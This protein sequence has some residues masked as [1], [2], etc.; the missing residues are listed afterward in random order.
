MC[1]AKNYIKA[2]GKEIDLLLNGFQTTLSGF[3]YIGRS[4]KGFEYKLCETERTNQKFSDI[5]ERFQ[6]S[7]RCYQVPES[8]VP[9]TPCK[10]DNAFCITGAKAVVDKQTG[11]KNVHIFLMDNSAKS[12]PNDHS[13]DQH[14]IVKDEH[15][16]C[17]PP[18]TIQLAAEIATIEKITEETVDISPEARDAVDC[19]YEHYSLPCNIAP[20]LKALMKGDDLELPCYKVAEIKDEDFV[21]LTDNNRPGNSE[22]RNFVNNALCTPDFTI[23]IGPPGSGKTTG[24]VELILQLVKRGKRIL[25]VAST[26]V[27]VDNILEKLQEHLD[28]SCVKRYGDEKSEKI[29][30][31]GKNFIVGKAFA[32]TEYKA[33]QQRLNAVPQKK[34]K[35]YRKELLQYCNPRDN[36][37]LY[38][39]L[40]ESAPITAG[41]TFG[42]AL[43][44][45]EK[46]G[47][48]DEPPFDYLIIDEASK[49]TVQEFLVPA[50]LCKHWIVVG[51][52]KQ[53]PPY[54]DDDHLAENL[55]ICYPEDTNK[56]REY[57]VASDTLLASTGSG[58]RQNVILI[59]KESNMDAYLYKKYCNQNEVLFADADN[60][61]YKSDM[62]Y[63]NIIVGSL[64]SFQKYRD[65]LS[66]RIT[67]VRPARDKLTN[68]IL[69]EVEMQEW[70]SIAR[71]NRENLFHRMDE[72]G[73]KEWHDELSWRLIRM[74]EQRDNNVNVDYS[75]LD[76]LKQ[77][78]L[79][80]I[81]DGDKDNCIK[82][83]HNFEQMYLPS[84]MEELIQGYGE[85]KD[86]AL[87]RGIPKEQ[88]DNRCIKL[89]YQH[90]SDQSIAQLASDEFYNG[91]AMRSEHMIGKREWNYN[92]FKHHNHWEHIK[93]FCDCKNRNKK[94]LMWIENELKKFG[95]FANQ[96]PQKGKKWSVATLSFYKEQ[97]DELKK[98][99]RKVFKD[100]KHV[101]YSAGSVDSFQGHE[102]DIVFLSYANQV[103]TCFIG[104]PNRYNVAITRARYMMVHVG[105]WTAMNKAQGG[106]GRIAQKLKDVTN[107]I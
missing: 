16:L 29:S 45:M 105:N 64:K 21:L 42:A 101:E 80:L 104:A 72:N 5:Q 14:G 32:K 46:L 50:V 60:D 62:P 100:N 24:T 88:L 26:N 68:R 13:R 96:N 7:T 34:L 51:D 90:R 38:S 93:G 98:I 99:C 63:A 82:N 48:K 76:R 39:F 86:I 28:K 73:P 1:T 85:Y 8:E 59:E 54:V 33:L 67:A 36:E 55:K 18:S 102:A 22:Q 75:T 81:P 53:L 9:R 25:L 27:A 84:F 95:S 12:N 70:V 30:H 65:F 2:I 19:F 69:H 92:R 74:F 37:M 56:K 79:A 52:I 58:L 4:S 20:T 87:L 3:E 11:E 89:S 106:L 40:E 6:F 83:M 107:N 49:T 78:Q 43:K 97:A 31:G 77:E 44:E 41:T 66:P 91:E 47:I 17:I 15:L 35:K 71:Y 61:D 10:P 57:A 94:E 23:K 103:P